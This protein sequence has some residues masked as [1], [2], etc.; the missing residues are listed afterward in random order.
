MVMVTITTNPGRFI[1][2]GT[3]TLRARMGYFDRGVIAVN[4]SAKI[5][6]AVW[7]VTTG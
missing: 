6:Q 7:D 1:Q 4:W 3:R 5:D 2:A